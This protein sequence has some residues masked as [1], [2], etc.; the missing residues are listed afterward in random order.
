MADVFTK[1]KRSDVMSRIRSKGTTIEKVVE[2]H[3]RKAG[4]RFRTHYK[5]CGCRV[6][7]A[8]PKKKIAIFVD[9]DFWHGWQYPRW[10]KKLPS[11][12]GERKSRAIERETDGSFPVSGE[13][14]GKSCV[15]GSMS[16]EWV[17]EKRSS[18]V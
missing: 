13:T 17:K 4:L 14:D 2:K 6:D 15:F 11:D 7:I 1:K 3:L 9:G 18:R 8:F 10:R 5:V 12:F 16:C